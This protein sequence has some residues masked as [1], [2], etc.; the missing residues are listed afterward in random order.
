[1]LL[2]LIAFTL[3]FLWI[4]HRNADAISDSLSGYFINFFFGIVASVIP[5]GFLLS[6]FKLIGQPAAWGLG[7]VAFSMLLSFIYRKI[8]THHKFILKVNVKHS[9]F[10]L[11]NIWKQSSLP[12][13]LIFAVLALGLT[14][15]TLINL[16][17]LIFSYP[18]EWDSMTGHLVKC[19]YYIQNGHMG[20][21]KA[22]TWSVDFYPRSLTTLQ[23]FFY[24]LLGE[25]G[26]NVIHYLAYWVFALAVFGISRQMFSSLKAALFTFFVA[27]LLPSALVQ[28]ITT[29]TD[30]VFTAYLS[31]LIYYILVFAK[32]PN[33]LNAF[34]GGII[35]CIWMGHKVTFIL[36]APALG[37]F[38]VFLLFRSKVPLKKLR[39]VLITVIIGFG[40]YVLPT[41]YIRNVKEVGVL[42]IGALSAPLEV[43]K[44]HGIEDYTTA[45]KIKNLKLNILRYSSDFL[46]LDG[47]RNTAEGAEINKKFRHYPNALFEK[48]KLERDEYWVVF[49]F[50]MMGDGPIAFYQERPFWGIISFGLVLPLIFIVFFKSFGKKP[51]T[52]QLISVFAI[53]GI[54]HFLCLC[55]TAPYD[56]IKGRYFM[57]MAVWFLPGT[58]YLFTM[59][60][61]KWYLVFCSFVIS[62]SA[63][64][65][66]AYRKVFPLFGEKTIFNMDRYEQM[67]IVRPETYQAFK[68]FNE[69]VPENAVVALGTQQAHEDYEYPLW[70]KSLTRKMIPL[71][72]FKEKVKPIPA[73]AEYLFY[74]KGVFEVQPGDIKLNDGDKLKDTA[75]PESEFYLR[76]LK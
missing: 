48:L 13:K 19:A 34:L 17:I 60:R 43:M 9:Y 1:M 70:G 12:E 46:Q 15:T 37:V 62:I 53:A 3:L 65:T 50:K 35:A 73:E 68:K 26:F 45:Q 66:V 14:G 67:T 72:P 71:H 30:L 42:R 56:P 16:I 31:V 32:K 58:G 57:N 5:T 20:E 36:V 55:F 24:H 23:I 29:E 7:V 41:G 18:N 28:S 52:A 4:T 47:L 33:T 74:S 40:I 51:K 63:I 6:A 10:D 69:I 76:K 22:T 49:P 44:W 11:I 75:V 59:K 8:S 38:V 2:I 27:A 21:V 54:V 64:T 39:A 61:M 25:K